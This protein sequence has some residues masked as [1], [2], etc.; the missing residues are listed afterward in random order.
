MKPQTTF[1]LIGLA[2]LIICILAMPK[3]EEQPLEL[4]SSFLIEAEKYEHLREFK[5]EKTNN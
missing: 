3:Q 4:D 1:R 5:D 2:I